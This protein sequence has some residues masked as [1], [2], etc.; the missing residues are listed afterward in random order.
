VLIFSPSALCTLNSVSA[1]AFCFGTVGSIPWDVGS[2][3]ED[4]Q[5]LTMVKRELVTFRWVQNHYRWII[6]KSACLV[7]SFPKLLHS[8]TPNEVLRQL[9][10]RY[11]AEYD[12]CKRSALRKIIE[13]D[14]VPTRPIILIV[15]RIFSHTEIEI[16]DGWYSMKA[17]LDTPLASLVKNGKLKEGVKII[18]VGATVLEVMFIIRYL[19]VK[20][21][22]L[23]MPWTLLLG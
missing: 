2:A 1:E 8:F 14:D 15:S 16:S 7:R 12:R 11:V 13:R 4:L 10:D 21:F 6:W 22:L 5:G 17:Q 9:L 23:W 19:P 20:E 18:S 3:Y